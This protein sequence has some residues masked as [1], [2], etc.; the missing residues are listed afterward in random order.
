M[1]LAEPVSTSYLRRTQSYP[2]KGRKCATDRRLKS[3]TYAYTA[4]ATA[5]SQADKQHRGKE[6]LLRYPDG[7]VRCIRYPIIAAEAERLA[8]QMDPT[9]SYE[10]DWDPDRWDD[11]DWAWDVL[12]SHDGA[13]AGAADAA[14]VRPLPQQAEPPPKVRILPQSC[15]WSGDS[16]LLLICQLLLSVLQTRHTF[17]S[18]ADLLRTLNAEG[19]MQAQQEL[20]QQVQ[21]SYEVQHCVA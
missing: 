9:V 21:T 19:Y 17:T 1:L 12:S 15:T 4:G 7:R 8:E 3:S 6:R 14:F 10:E 18:P 16:L 5:Y 2:A 11:I 20:L 13:S